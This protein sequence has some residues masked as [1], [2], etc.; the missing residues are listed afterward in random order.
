MTARRAY[1]T[2]RRGGNSAS[3]G[4]AMV[5]CS[6]LRSARPGTASSPRPAMAPL[7]YGIRLRTGNGSSSGRPRNPVERNSFAIGA[8]YTAWDK[9][10]PGKGYDA[11]AAEWKG[12]LGD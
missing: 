5:G 8:L 11:K 2:R 4:I 9:A 3:C 1:G 12:K 6:T 10:E 7:G